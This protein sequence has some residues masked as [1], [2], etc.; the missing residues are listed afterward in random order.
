MEE[1]SARELCEHLPL[2]GNI[3]LT[4]SQH[5]KSSFMGQRFS[6]HNTFPLPAQWPLLPFKSRRFP[7]CPS[8]SILPSESH[9][10]TN[11]TSVWIIV[12]RDLRSL[13]VTVSLWVISHCPHPRVRHRATFFGESEGE[14]VVAFS[15]S[16][17]RH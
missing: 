5:P 4:P 2:R 11:P 13:P 16:G 9:D 3:N 8:E 12:P 15:A 1:T 6:P 7:S 10:P 17:V 14:M